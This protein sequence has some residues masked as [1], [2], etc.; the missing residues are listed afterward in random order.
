VQY[1]IITLLTLFTP[2][3]D[4]DRIADSLTLQAVDIVAPLKE[5]NSN[6][7][8]YSASTFT[9]KDFENRHI[10]S[11]KELSAFAPNFYQP[12]YGSRMTSSIYVRGFGSRIDQ[13]VIGMNIDGAPVMNKNNYDFELFDISKIEIIR[14]AQSTLYG[15]NTAAGT[16]NI[17]TLSPLN[18][19]GKRFTM[20]YG[21]DN[22]IRIK[23]SHYAAPDDNRGWSASIHYNHTDGHFTNHYNGRKCD[24]GD[25]FAT[26]LRG[27]MLIGERWSID[28]S[29]TIG[30][31]DEG[32]YA[33]RY[34][35]ESSSTLLPVNYNDPCSYRRFGLNN[36]LTIKHTLP[37]AI[38]SSTTGYNYTDD[39]M[40]IDNDFLP[41]SY[42]TLGQ[43]QREH[44]VTQEFIVKSDNNS[45]FN[46]LGGLFAFYKHQQLSA[47]VLFKE[48]GI[49]TLILD[50]A[51]KGLQ[52][53]FPGSEL[54]FDKEE[55]TIHDD[56][57][58]PTYGAAIYTQAG[59]DTKKW[60]VTAG[61]RVDYEHTSMEYHS[62]SQ[63]G[64]RLYPNMKDYLPLNTDFKGSNSLN[65]TEIMPKLSATLK[66][67]RG[68]IYASVAKGYKA[69]G[70]NTQLFSDILQ[71]RMK[72]DLMQK[73]GVTL[74][75][76]IYYDDASA[77]TYR[78]EESWNYEIGTHLSP[79]KDGTLDISATLFLIDCTNQ[80]LTVFPEGL[81]TGRMMSN[82]GESRSYGG[83]F[84]LSY[85]LQRLTLDCSYGYTHATFRKYTSGKNDY[86]GNYLP[87]APRE[88]MSAN[89]SYRLPVSEK[90][91]KHLI[92]NI[93]WSGTGRIYWNESNSLSQAF[94]GL[95]SASLNWERGHFGASLWGKNLLNEE[96]KAFYFVSMQHPFFSL[97]KSRQFGIS[98]H[99]YL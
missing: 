47:P 56:F 54:Q 26:R 58:T 43:Y 10:S 21:T 67:N 59:Y 71:N 88:T 28:N 66:L 97:G 24:A 94:Y 95:T 20:E 33:Y 57:T 62:S 5:N 96:Y 4:H 49:K 79:L 65:A 2:I 15:R 80:Q 18:F 35:D 50:N 14:G 12:D 1:L 7:N 53:A 77:T 45:R 39:R 27:Q 19:Q 6:D 92:L 40:R 60:N 31:T 23:A 3:T 82:A 44:S 84:S 78:P 16:I 36:G 69:G 86:S 30:Y 34:Y 81:S 89:L 91:A 17:Q 42:F 85:R 29:L 68:T 8:P 52:N 72:N 64:F 74:D 90:Y 37:K 38:L 93:G 22:N 83:E 46:W 73:F 63:I 55:F 61:V 13:P 99:Y 70:F 98:L 32:G 51:N 75:N 87:L 41:E 11:L 25:N 76:A 9:L 48:Q